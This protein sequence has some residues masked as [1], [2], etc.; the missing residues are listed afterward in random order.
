MTIDATT[1]Q[2]TIVRGACPHDCPDT[3]AMLYHVEDGKLVDVQGDPNHPMTRGGLCVKVKNFHEHHYQPDR[4][5]YPMRRV[6]AKGVGEFERIT[7]DEALAEIKSRWTEIIGEY[8][9]QAIMPHA[10]LGHQGVLNGLTSGDAFFNRL[11]STVAEKTYCESGSSTAWHMTVGGSGGLD[12]ESMAYSKYIIVWGMNMTSTNLHGWPFLLEARK[13]NGA[14]IVVIDPVRNRTARQADWHI[15]IRPGTDGALAMGMINEIITQGLVDTDYVER[16][17]V[18]YDELAERAANYPPERVEEITGIPADDI[19]TLAYEYATSQPAAIR[20]GVALERSRGGGQAIRAITCL[21]ALVGAWRHVG[22]G[23]MEMPI[24]EFPTKFD[25]I[26]KPEWIPEGTRVVNELDLGMALTGEMEL[27]PP[28]KSLFVYNSNPVSQGPAQEKTMR[29]LMREDLFTVVSE[30]FVTDTAKFADI[31]LP[32]TMQAEQLDIMVTW[33]HL[34]I[35]LNQPAIEPPGECVPN[36]ELFRRL[37]RAMEFDDESMAYWNRTDREML[38]D[39]HDWDAPALEGI[40]Y[41]KLEEVGWMRLAVGTPD[42]RA[43]HAEGNFPTPS[44]KC[45]FKSSLA[46]GGNFVV[47][48]WRS[49]Y[50]GM[51]PGGYVDPVPDYVPPFESPQSNPELAQRYPLS[52]ISPKPHAFLNSQYG[53][54]ADKQK[55][56]GGQRVFIHPADA[57]E[58]GIAEGDMVRVFNDRGAFQGPAAFDDGLIPGLVMANVGHWQGKSSGTTVNAITADRHCGLGN[59][60][61]YGDNLVEVE[62]IAEEAVAS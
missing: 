20:Q 45:E 43:P 40:T 34:Y 33:G 23:T 17:T 9:S 30:H 62:K 41:E 49:M 36:V 27:D 57:A 55:V 47:P 42:V 58:R 18:G 50:E 2:L 4:L 21:P 46:E 13:N 3:C 24:W 19:R 7:W 8:G 54:A 39:F 22:G 25:A 1:K 29:G 10:Y 56:Q 51:Q 60:G 53:N 26:C 11:G 59:A 16:Y 6:G 14:K 28:I 32:A 5:L 15:P 37:A 61:V 35:S 52:I 44:G 12:V 38:I 48:V 31:L